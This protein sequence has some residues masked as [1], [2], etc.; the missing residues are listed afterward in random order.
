MLPVDSESADLAWLVET[1]SR[2]E[3]LLGVTL[4]SSS[5]LGP[6]I[7]ESQST[8][9]VMMRRN[10][11]GRWGRNQMQSTLMSE[12]LSSWLGRIWCVPFAWNW[13]SWDSASVANASTGVASTEG[14]PRTILGSYRGGELFLMRLKF[15][16]TRLWDNMSNGAVKKYWSSG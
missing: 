8:S 7:C 11:T 6:S 1:H 9:D 15:A 16:N 13:D 10:L 4:R 2:D 12:S 14:T 3:S 5:S